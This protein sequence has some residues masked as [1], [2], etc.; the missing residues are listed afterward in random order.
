MMATEIVAEIR[1]LPAMERAEAERFIRNDDSAARLSPE[2]LGDLAMRL[3]E[4]NDPAKA[5]QLEDEIV[6][7]FYGKK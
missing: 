3:A 4:T 5:D 2:E 7:G 6:S 1:N